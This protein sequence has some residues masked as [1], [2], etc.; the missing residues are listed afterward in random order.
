MKR[1]RWPTSGA[2]RRFLRSHA[3]PP[4][5]RLPQRSVCS[6]GQSILEFS[7]LLP[8]LLVLLLG[9]VELSYALVDQ[10]VVTRLAREGSNLISRDT[11][12]QDAAAAMRTMASR[13]VNFDDGSKLI[14]SVLKRGATTG[15]SNYDKVILYQ[16]YEFGSLPGQSALRTAGPP[17][18]GGP[19]NYEAA[20]SDNNTGLQIANV[21]SDLVAVKGG[22]IYVTEIFTRHLLIT[23]L[24]GFGISVPTTLYS[25]AYF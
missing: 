13:P 11:L 12:F 18:F 16:R 1:N 15:T 7:L 14:F 20:N 9:L 4:P 2:P 8:F 6:S 19:P 25:I 22:M 23:P 17:T 5:P 10:H 3:A 21:P 24:D